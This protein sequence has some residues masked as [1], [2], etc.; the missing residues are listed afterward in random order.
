MILSKFYTRQEAMIKEIINSR[1][2]IENFIYFQG[3]PEEILQS[4]LKEDKAE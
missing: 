1:R 4:L 2:I 3:M